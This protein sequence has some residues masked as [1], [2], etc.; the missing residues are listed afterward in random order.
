MKT[1]AAIPIAAGGFYVLDQLLFHGQNTE[2]VIRMMQA[3]A[4]VIGLYF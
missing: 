4:T 3:V 2:L 1:F